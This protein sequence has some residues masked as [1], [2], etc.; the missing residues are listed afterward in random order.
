MKKNEMTIAEI[1]EAIKSMGYDVRLEVL[2]QMTPSELRKFLKKV[3]KAYNLVTELD[4]KVDELESLL[5]DFLA[6]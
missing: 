2:A 3:R 6:E 5:A 1:H 4:N